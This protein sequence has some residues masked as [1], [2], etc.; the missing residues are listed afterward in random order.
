M[1]WVYICQR[2]TFVG[3]QMQTFFQPPEG[4]RQYHFILIDS[5]WPEQVEKLTPALTG[6]GKRVSGG[7]LKTKTDSRICHC[8]NSW[9]TK[10]TQL[11]LYG[12]HYELWCVLKGKNNAVSTDA[13]SITSSNLKKQ[14][15]SLYIY[16]H[17]QTKM[18]SDT[19]NI[20]FIIT[21]SL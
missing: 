21:V 8:I 20:L 3:S 12:P 19:F 14:Q 16:I 6:K 13:N 15:L 17:S 9:S 18:Y 2:K 10:Q 4:S 11:T 1:A 5:A 7:Q